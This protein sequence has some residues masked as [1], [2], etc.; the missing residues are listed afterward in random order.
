[1]RMAQTRG[2]NRECS[3]WSSSTNGL[4]QLVQE[5]VNQNLSTKLEYLEYVLLYK[6]ENRT[7]NKVQM[8]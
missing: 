1:M 4:I 8:V 2:G 6:A 5:A 7:I 3:G